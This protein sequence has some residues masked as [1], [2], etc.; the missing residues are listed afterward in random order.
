MRKSILTILCALSATSVCMGDNLNSVL[1]NAQRGLPSAMNQL[2]VW[3]YTGNNVEKDY[4]KA[5]YWWRRGALEQNPKA[6]ANL[7]VCYQF[8][9]GVERDSTEAVR[10]Y[11]AAIAAGQGELLK[12]RLANSSSNAFDA[13]LSGYCLEKGVGTEQDMGQAAECYASAAA[14]GSTDGMTRAGKAFL[15]LSD[16]KR[17]L[18]YLEE[19]ASRGDNEA[20]FIAGTILMGNMGVSTDKPRAIKL[21]R[22]SAQGGN[23]GAQRQLGLMSLKG[24]GVYADTAEAKRWLKLAASNGDGEGMWHYANAL[25]DSGDFDGALFWYANASQA[26]YLDDFKKMANSL[27]AN[28]PFGNY[29]RGMI[30]YKVNGDYDLADDYFKKVEKDKIDD[31]KV[32]RAIVQ[33]DSRNPRRNPSKA[34][35]TLESLASSNAHAATALA[36]M[37]TDANGIPRSNSKAISLLRTAVDAD[38]GMAADMLGNMYFTGTGTNIDRQGAAVL[39]KKAFASRCLSEDGRK[40]LLALHSEGV[41]VDTPTARALERYIPA[42]NILPLLKGTY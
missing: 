3:Y 10:L 1:A 22:K 31:G 6:I 26:G 38:Y 34:A 2:G 25:K 30:A 37:L 24:D 13:M 35:K 14:M 5:Y 19:A 41:S 9:K 33:A 27:P 21:L 11:V 29:L 28:S 15:K 16:P 40:R 39:L 42:D 12:Q 4:N 36:K 18:T 7:G 23:A 20:A 17:A 32:M 8:G